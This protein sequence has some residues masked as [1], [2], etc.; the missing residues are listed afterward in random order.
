[1]LDRAKQ[2]LAASSVGEN[3]GCRASENRPADAAPTRRRRRNACADA[4]EAFWDRRNGSAAP[5]ESFLRAKTLCASPVGP[6]SRPP[7]R[8]QMLRGHFPAPEASPPM[9]R[10]LFR[11][12][13]DRPQT[14][15]FHATRPRQLHPRAPTPSR[16]ADTAG[17]QENLG[18]NSCAEEITPRA[19]ASKLFLPRLGRRA[20]TADWIQNDEGPARGGN[21]RPR[22]V[23]GSALNASTHNGQHSVTMWSSNWK[24]QSASPSRTSF[25]QTMHWLSPVNGSSAKEAMGWCGR[26]RPGWHRAAS[27]EFRRIAGYYFL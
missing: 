6:F 11:L 17:R 19:R 20:R 26:S 12:A 10:P 24:R 3:R 14:P 13:A 23:F 18:R 4:V 16:P 1:L 2:R 5:V 27:P 25:R 21:T 7:T 15:R 9:L 8:A 22:Y